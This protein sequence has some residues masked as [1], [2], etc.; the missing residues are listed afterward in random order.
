MNFGFKGQRRITGR[1]LKRERLDS[2]IGSSGEKSGLKERTS[3]THA[4]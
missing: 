3:H 4:V 1:A 2:D